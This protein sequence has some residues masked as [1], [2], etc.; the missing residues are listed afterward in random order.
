ME[1]KVLYL[2]YGEREKPRGR[3]RAYCVCENL[4]IKK[5]WNSEIKEKENIVLWE[6]RDRRG[7]RKGESKKEKGIVVL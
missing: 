3:R 2:S 7:W 6:K 5:R 4:K 1:E